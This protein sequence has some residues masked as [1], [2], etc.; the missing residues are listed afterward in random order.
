MQYRRSILAMALIMVVLVG[1][2]GADA[3]SAPAVT[4]GET[5]ASPVLG[6]G[7]EGALTVRNQFALGILGLEGK[8]TEVTQAQAATMLPLWQGLRG[9]IR[10]GASATAEVDAL[11]SQ[12][13]ET[14]TPA[15]LEAIAAMQLTQE[16]MGE[17]AASQGITLGA[18]AGAGGGVGAGHGLSDEER[19]TRQAENGGAGAGGSGGMSTALLDAV[20]SYLERRT[21]A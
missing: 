21:D 4:N 10:S 3:S 8:D 12:I 5:Y 19:A 20:I 15:Q 2:G 11:L 7:Y 6:T 1:C 9:T 14:V 17:W 16:R 13:E 18:G